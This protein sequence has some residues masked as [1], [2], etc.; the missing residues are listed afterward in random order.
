[1]ENIVI[2]VLKDILQINDP[3]EIVGQWFKKVHIALVF[4]H[5]SYSDVNLLIQFSFQIY[6]TILI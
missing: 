1:M 2:R 5:V 6:N 4:H 3:F